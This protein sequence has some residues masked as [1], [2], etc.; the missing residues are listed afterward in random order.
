MTIKNPYMWIKSMCNYNKKSI[1]NKL[2]I[3]EK[4]KLWNKI[5]SNYKKYIVR[6]EAYLIKY[7]FLLQE[8]HKILEDLIQKFNLTRKYESAFTFEKNKLLPN[9]DNTIGKCANKLF[10]PTKYINP[11]ITAVLP[12][13]TIN[14]INN[15]I[16]FKLMEFYGYNNPLIK[17]L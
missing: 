11:N 10:N 3:I 2:Y 12:I 15:N 4:I 17:N 16:D 8:P 14:I 9:T 1:R 7:E 5:Y 6:G 13:E